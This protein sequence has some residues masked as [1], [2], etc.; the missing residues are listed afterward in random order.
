MVETKPA[1]FGANL[2]VPLGLRPARAHFVI[3]LARCPHIAA[4]RADRRAGP[5]T[6]LPQSGHFML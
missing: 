4:F 1:G 2:P 6:E 3:R 5:Q